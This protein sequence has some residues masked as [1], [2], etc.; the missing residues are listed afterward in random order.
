M[1]EKVFYVRTQLLIFLKTLLDE[2]DALAAL[3]ER[4]E[5]GITRLME[6]NLSVDFFV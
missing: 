1:L 3:P 6:Q 5:P 4:L 2:V